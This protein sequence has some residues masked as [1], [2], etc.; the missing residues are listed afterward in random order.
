MQV[1][2]QMQAAMPAST[3]FMRKIEGIARRYGQVLTLS[4]RI[5]PVHPDYTYRAVNHVVQGSA[6]DQLHHAVLTL[7][8]AG[9]GD[10]IL[11]AMHDEL[12]LDCDEATSK[13]VEHLMQTPHPGLLA[14]SGR[15]S[16]RLRTDRESTG[17]N[18]T[19]V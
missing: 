2:R 8:D 14:W 17:R 9:L 10:T 4:G 5:L 15:S 12:V 7:E 6:A 18:W 3:A 19:K 11:V 13:E 1:R 16:V